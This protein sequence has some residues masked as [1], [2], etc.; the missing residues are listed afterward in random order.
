SVILSLGTGLSLLVAV[1]LAN[2][3]IVS[4]LSSRLPQNS[5]DYFVLDIPSADLGSLTDLVQRETPSAH[6]NSAPMLRGRLV[7]LNDTP[8]DQIKAAPESSWVLTGDRG[9]TFADE[10]PEGSTITKGAW[11]P[12]DYA[13]EPLVSFEAELARGLNL[14]VGDTV[15][16]NVLG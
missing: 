12:A 14:H 7:R 8:V 1:A 16:V 6:V 9:L 4:E 13:G 3:S 10:V 15:T 2:S 11:W 5:P